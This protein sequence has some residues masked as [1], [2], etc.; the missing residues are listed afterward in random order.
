MSE[1]GVISGLRSG[2][3]GCPLYY[4]EQASF[5]EPSGPKSARSRPADIERRE[6]YSYFTVSQPN[7]LGGV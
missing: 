7:L 6:G 2:T 3:H 4:D 1:M 5:C